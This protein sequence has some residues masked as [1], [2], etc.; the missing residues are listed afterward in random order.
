VRLRIPQFVLLGPNHAALKDS[1]I[2]RQTT[3][4]C[5]VGTRQI[6]VS[7]AVCPP[8]APGALTQTEPPHGICGNVGQ[9]ILGFGP[10]PSRSRKLHPPRLVHGNS[11]KKFASSSRCSTDQRREGRSASNMGKYGPHRWVHPSSSRYIHCYLGHDT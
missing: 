3:N 8:I 4:S 5:G 1:Q 2:R 11:S 9:D 7:T 6:L 10:P